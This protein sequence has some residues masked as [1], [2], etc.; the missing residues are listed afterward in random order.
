MML[1]LAPDF[2]ELSI[3]HFTRAT[4]L[5]EAETS[6]C[7]DERANVELDRS[8]QLRILQDLKNAYPSYSQ[9]RP[10]WMDAD[11]D[12]AIGTL[13]YLQE[14]GLVE[15]GLTQSLSGSWIYSGARITAMGMDFLAADGGLSAIL[16]TVTVRLDAIQWTEFLAQKIE[17]AAGV[18]SE[19]RSSLAKAIRNLPAKAVEKLSE[20]MLDWAVDHAGDAMPMLRAFLAQAIS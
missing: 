10:N 11:E 1:D 19:E 16:K 7:Y 15:A 18:S 3:A 12:L 17:K 4:K 6:A 8:L 9:G 13:R 14:H 20:K 2:H 5:W